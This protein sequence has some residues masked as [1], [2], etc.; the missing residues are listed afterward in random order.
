MGGVRIQREGVSATVWD[1][2]T[3]HLTNGSW[4]DGKRCNPDLGAPYWRA[5]K[6]G[7]RA[8]E[9]LLNRLGP[10]AKA[11]KDKR[12]GWLVERD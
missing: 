1:T 5:F 2:V 9:E 4:Q 12:H 6:T 3:N 8:L 10:G 11:T 7:K